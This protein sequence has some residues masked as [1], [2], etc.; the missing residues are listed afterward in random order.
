MY[1]R[2]DG[3]TLAT[4]QA[5]RRFD[6]LDGM[7]GIAALAIVV[8]HTYQHAQYPYIA[9]ATHVVLTSLDAAVDLFF[10]LSGFVIFLPFARA[11]IHNTTGPSTQTFLI[12][13][14]ARIVP[15]YYAL[16]LLVWVIRYD[17]YPGQ[18]RDLWQHLT[19][20][21]VFD[22]ERIFWTIGPAW[23]IANEV[24]Y[25]LGTAI[26]AIPLVALCRRIKSHTAR[27]VLTASLP[28]AAI[29]VSMAW[30]TWAYESGIPFDH[31]PTYFGPL[32]RM[33]GFAWGMVLAVVVAARTAVTGVEPQVLPPWMLMAS[34]FLG[35][36]LVIIAATLRGPYE[37]GALFFHSL[38]SIGFLLIMVPFVFTPKANRPTSPWLSSRP[39]LLLGAISYGIY[40]WHEPLLIEFTRHQFL[41][42]PGPDGFLRNALIL[43]LL[44]VLAATVTYIV[45]ERPA[46][47]WAAART[48]KRSKASEDLPAGNPASGAVP[49]PIVPKSDEDRPK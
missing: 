12:R 40:L 9:T 11:T 25:Y 18:V 38:C 22:A 42:R 21:H 35:T 37:Y 3:A 20:T 44:A 41:L 26:L 4:T 15:L 23:S 7:R 30:K 31:W 49:P 29:L 10:V 36:G 19:F 48:P 5:S 32:A 45:I 46:I 2:R 14:A 47:T 28:L 13:R 16:I 43:P 1:C 34:T 33:D 39:M 6:E 27:T 17:A 24:M 8:F